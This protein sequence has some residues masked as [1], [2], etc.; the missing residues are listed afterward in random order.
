M[1]VVLRLLGNRY[2]LAGLLVVGIGAVLLVARLM[3][4]GSGPPPLTTGAESPGGAGVP[5][6]VAGAS[7]AG[8]ST[9]DD[10]GPDE[11]GVPDSPGQ[12]STSPGAAGPL[13][14]ANLFTTA[15]LRHT[16][17]SAQDW[18]AG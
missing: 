18:Y 6:S 2:A 7:A 15:W 10:D 3:G 13:A 5:A 11:G 9:Q 14:V 12:P 1:R 8:L 16:G 4:G 17:V